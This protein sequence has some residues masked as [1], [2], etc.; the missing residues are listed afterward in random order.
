MLWHCGD[1]GSVCLR[2]CV[3]TVVHLKLC[4]VTMGVASETA[5]ASSA[6]FFLYVEN[7][8]IHDSK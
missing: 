2:L 7:T 1:I 3:V 4:D 6:I 8:N 5:F